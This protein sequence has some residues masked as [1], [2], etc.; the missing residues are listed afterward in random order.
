MW[1]CGTTRRDCRRDADHHP[2]VGTTADRDSCRSRPVGRPRFPRQSQPTSG[3]SQRVIATARWREGRSVQPWRQGLQKQPRGY[4][5][6]EMPGFSRAPE[7]G[8]SHVRW[9]AKRVVRSPT[10]HAKGIHCSSTKVGGNVFSTVTSSLSG[11]G[12]ASLAVPV[13]RPSST[14][15]R[16]PPA[17]GPFL[18]L[19]NF[20]A[21]IFTRPSPHFFTFSLLPPIDPKRPFLLIAGPA[22]NLLHLQNFPAACSRDIFICQNI[23]PESNFHAPAVGAPRPSS[24]TVRKRPPGR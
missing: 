12:N 1:G 18:Q 17:A 19:Q 23:L 20:P 4:C 8:G 22:T 13:F 16:T 21:R 3:W 9:C 2:W 6:V 11:T 5:G 15:S 14:R 24:N 7:D 10:H